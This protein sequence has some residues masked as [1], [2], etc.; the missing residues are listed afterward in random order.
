M[1]ADERGTSWAV[2]ET[3]RAI[4]S[5]SLG[6]VSTHCRDGAERAYARDR[7]AFSRPK[8]RLGSVPA[9]PAPAT[10]ASHSDVLRQPST[11]F[12]SQLTSLRASSDANRQIIPAISP[13]DMSLDVDHARNH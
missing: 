13:K 7:R 1:Q 9:S 8:S 6:Q 4:A 12:A 5:S 10:A 3:E 2:S 11:P